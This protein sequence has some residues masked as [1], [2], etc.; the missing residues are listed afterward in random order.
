MFDKKSKNRNVYKEEIPEETRKNICEKLLKKHPDRIPTIC[1]YPSDIQRRIPSTSGKPVKY[2]KFLLDKDFIF[3]NFLF[4]IRKR[5][6]LNPTEGLFVFA[7]S[8]GGVLPPGS[9]LMSQVYNDYK[10][11]DDG[12]L[13]LHI[14][15]ENTFGR[16]FME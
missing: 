15:K 10:D 3:G 13:Y 7:S 6:K 1:L 5:F 14:A 8:G 12:Y 4:L 16:S 2:H 11:P 9:S